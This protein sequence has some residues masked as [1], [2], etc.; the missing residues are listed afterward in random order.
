MKNRS[1]RSGAG[2]R[3]C[4]REFSQSPS[5]TLLEAPL[6]QFFLPTIQASQCACFF[7]LQTIPF[8]FIS[9]PRGLGTKYAA[10]Q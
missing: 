2:V 4:R 7:F 8:L 10:E 9:R 5:G 3:R 1:S 6:Q